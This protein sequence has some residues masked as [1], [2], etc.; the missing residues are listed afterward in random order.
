MLAFLLFCVTPFYFLLLI[1][2]GETRTTRRKHETLSQELGTTQRS[3]KQ[4]NLETRD[5]NG[6]KYVFMHIIVGSAYKLLLMIPTSLKVPP[7][8]HKTRKMV[9]TLDMSS[10]LKTPNRY[11]YNY[12]HWVSDFQMMKN[13]SID[14]AALNIGKTGDWQHQQILSAYDAATAVGFSVFISFDYTSFDCNTTTTIS[15]VNENKNKPSQFKVNGKPFISSFSGYCL[16]ASGWM[17]VKNSTGGYLMPFIYGQDD[18]QLKSTGTWGFLDSWLCWGCAWPQGN[19]SKNTNDDMYYY[20]ILGK[21][22]A[23]TV[24][25]WFYTHYSKDNRYLRGDDW[26]INTRWEEIVQMR[27]NITFVEMVAWND[28]GE[29][30]Y[31]GPLSSGLAPDGTTWISNMPHNPWLDLSKWYITAYKTGT[32]P[33]VTQDGIYYW[34]RP[35]PASIQASN[36]PLPKPT[37]W[38]WTQDTLWAVVFCTGTPCSATLK[39]GTVSQQFNGLVVGV[40]KIK[41]LLAGPGSVTVQMQ[42]NG[43]LVVND[44]PSDFQYRNTTVTYNYN[45]YVRYAGGTAPVVKTSNT[46]VG[47]TLGLDTG[48]LLDGSVV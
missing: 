5:V 35:H 22:L 20:S 1:S 14:A 9:L 19:Y 2:L 4:P 27:D 8:L 10:L 48:S 44:T 16:G 36:D 45:A 30:S 29:S 38:N 41:L 7:I 26:L 6:T 15:Y 46:V 23:Y 24:S 12:S 31:M 47:L 33:P 40:N 42:R 37:G 28:F 25:P 32:Y 17:T 13:Y 11:N 3:S 21:R 34:L 18:Q 43:Q 39:V